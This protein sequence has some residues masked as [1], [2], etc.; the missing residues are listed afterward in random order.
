MRIQTAI[1]YALEIRRRIRSVNGVLATPLCRFE[2]IRIARVWVF[3]STVKGSQAP[4][5]L[6]VLLDIRCA[7]RHRTWRQAKLSKRA[8]RSCGVW[9]A[10]ESDDEFL[11]WLTRG[12][13]KVSRHVLSSEPSLEHDLDVKVLLY[14][15]DDFSRHMGIP[16]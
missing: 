8:L 15:R 14:P 4:N 12:M 7:G 6:D 11:K 5:D 13:R 9:L 1:K 16:A 2:A 3:G 10:P